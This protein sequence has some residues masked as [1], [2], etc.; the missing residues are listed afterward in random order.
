MFAYATLRKTLS[1]RTVVIKP[2][3]K[4]L[5]FFINLINSFCFLA[6]QEDSPSEDEKEIGTIPDEVLADFKCRQ[7][8]IQAL[9]EELRQ[10]LRKKFNQMCVKTRM[11]QK[12][13]P[14]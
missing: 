2:I 1:Y 9:R 3:V 14:H 4:M 13:C 11:A 7:P 8:K 10:D 6:K 12:V 5:E